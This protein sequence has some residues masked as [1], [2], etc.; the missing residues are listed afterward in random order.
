MFVDKSRIPNAGNGLF[1][2][3]DIPENTTIGTYCGTVVSWDT[4]QQD[5]IQAI[6]IQQRTNNKYLMVCRKHKYKGFFVVSAQSSHCF[7]K[8]INDPRN[9]TRFPVNVRFTEFG[10]VQTLTHICA[11]QELYGTYTQDYWNTH[12]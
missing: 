11:Q 1:A 5:A 4:H 6:P 8:F 12:T 9:D 3:K 2:K 10:H 7:M